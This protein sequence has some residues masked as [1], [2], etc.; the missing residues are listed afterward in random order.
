MT[1]LEATLIVGVYRVA[2]KTKVFIVRAYIYL[3]PKFRADFYCARYAEM[4]GDWGNLGPQERGGG[5]IR[6]GDKNFVRK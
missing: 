6:S 1:L 4:R 2:E 5:E 3:L